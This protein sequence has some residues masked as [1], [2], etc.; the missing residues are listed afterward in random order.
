MKNKKYLIFFISLHL[1]FFITIPCT[2]DSSKEIRSALNSSPKTTDS[3]VIYKHLV[4]KLKGVSSIK[5]KE[6]ISIFLAEYAT[7]NNLF[8]NAAENYLE[9][10]NFA[11]VL[12]EKKRKKYLVKALKSFILAG[13]MEMGHSIYEKLKLLKENPPSI[14]DL[15][16]DLYLQ[17]LKLSNLLNNSAKGLDK[18]IDTLKA[19]S[20]DSKYKSFRRSILLSLWFISNDEEAEWILKKEYPKSIEAMLVKGEALILPTTFWYLLPSSQ[21]YYVEEDESFVPSENVKVSIPKAYQIGFFKYK[22]Y[23]TSQAKKLKDM[24]FT[25][26]IKEE[27]RESGTLYFAVFVVENEEGNIGLKLKDLGFETFPI[28]D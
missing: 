21:S 5:E 8:K 2:S 9:T 22:K 25:V 10:F 12:K 18:V 6:E 19:Y 3:T 13:D 7:R 26:E 27:T 14:Y 17:Y 4:S 28:F 16:G 23:A 20:K 11:T 15:E 24:G 1:F